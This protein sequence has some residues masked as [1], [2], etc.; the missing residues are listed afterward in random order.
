MEREYK[1]RVIQ[2]LGRLGI[3][4]IN[5]GATTGQNWLDTQGDVT[6]SVSPI[7]GE[8]IATVNN[9]TAKDYETVVQTAEEAFATWKTVPAPIRGEVVRQIGL[10]LRESK[11]DLA[12]LVTQIGRAHV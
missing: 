6:A 5:S 3:Q 2:V 1:D 10:A 8:A 4:N 11:E 7:D 9:A 12:F